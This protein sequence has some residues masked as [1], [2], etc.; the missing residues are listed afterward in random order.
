[1]LDGTIHRDYKAAISA[2]SDGI[3]GAD[4]K[5][6][7]RAETAAILRLVVNAIYLWFV[8]YIAS[9]FPDILSLKYSV[10]ALFAFIGALSLLY[11]S[12]SIRQ[13]A[14]PAYLS[15]LSSS[16]MSAIIKIVGGLMKIGIFV[17]ATKILI[18]AA[19]ETAGFEYLT[20]IEMV[21]DISM[22]ALT[23]FEPLGYAAITI[24]IFVFGTMLLLF[25]EPS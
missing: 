2:I 9:E 18:L 22:F 16:F 8:V 13:N 15:G 19:E 20:E 11:M 14:A 23:T 24:G 7:G 10:T 21:R 4:K 5:L 17:V 6:T 3:A 12:R 25:P 1:M